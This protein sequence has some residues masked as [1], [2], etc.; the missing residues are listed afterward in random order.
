MRAL[1]GFAGATVIAGTAAARANPP[2][3]LVFLVVG[4]VRRGSD[5]EAPDGVD[6]TETRPELQLFSSE[7]IELGFDEA[8]CDDCPGEL[9]L[10]VAV[11]PRGPSSNHQGVVHATG[12]TSTDL[13]TGAS[14]TDMLTGGGALGG[15]TSST[16]APAIATPVVISGAIDSRDGPAARLP[17]FALDILQPP[18]RWN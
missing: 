14:G 18:R 8:S 17:A 5:S 16:L 6:A 9:L 15:L 3:P 2:G 10:T 11:L 13:V 7:P 12:I 1:I 4:I